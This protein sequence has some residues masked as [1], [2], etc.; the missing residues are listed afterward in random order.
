[1]NNWNI[2]PIARRRLKEME[3]AGLKEQS[4]DQGIPD[5][6]GGCCVMLENSGNEEPF[7]SF[8][9]YGNTIGRAIAD[10]WRQWKEENAA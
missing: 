1:M 5:V 4:M 7:Q 8:V 9:G 6:S 10:A 2:G 3:C